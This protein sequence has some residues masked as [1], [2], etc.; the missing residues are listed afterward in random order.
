[1]KHVRLHLL[2]GSPRNQFALALSLASL[3]LLVPGLTLS[4]LHIHTTGAV[5][6]PLT[7]FDI[8]VFDTNNSILMTISDLF[9]QGYYFVSTMIFVFSVIIPTA[10][11]MLLIQVLFM[12]HSQSR[13]NIIRFIKQIGKWSMCDVFIVAIFLAYLSTGSRS[14]GETHEKSILGIP[15]EID[16]LVNMTA[17]LE[18][19]F[20]FFLG[21]CLCS[22]FA[23][24]FFE[25]KH[26][27]PQG[28]LSPNNTSIEKS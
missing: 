5:D 27:Q 23:L 24:Q 22:L 17:T 19:G 10:K 26:G 4:M 8:N 15:I 1:M 13:T 9:N 14:S 18:S 28:P 2:K 16:V 20:Y 6:V 25:E 3:V 7:N 12:Q 11:I 21:Y